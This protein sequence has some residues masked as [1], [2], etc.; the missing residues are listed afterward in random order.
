M[1]YIK[2]PCA[3]TGKISDGY[4]TFDELYAHRCTLFLALMRALPGFAWA[5]R[6]H[7]GD[8]AFSGWFLAGMNLPLNGERQ[9]VT[10]HIPMDLWPLAEATG[11]KILDRAPKWDG[12]TSNDVL[13]RLKAWVRPNDP[14]SA[15]AAEKRSD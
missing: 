3:D 8:E 11:A 9:T 6:R 7:D 4:H 13:E 2:I 10:Y 5:A 12:H 15:T 14:S 1:T